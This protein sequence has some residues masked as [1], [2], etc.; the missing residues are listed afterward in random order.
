LMPGT[1]QLLAPAGEADSKQGLWHAAKSSMR[2]AVLY[3]N[4]NG[5]PSA[6]GQ[7]G[8]FYSIPLS[9]G[10]DP[11]LFSDNFQST[12]GMPFFAS[13]AD[14]SFLLYQ[15]QQGGIQALE[16]MSTHGLNLSIP[17]SR[18]GETI[19]VRSARWVRRYP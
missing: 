2:I 6:A 19:G 16:L 3:F 14:G 4:N 15:R 11:F 7:V 5:V 17:L 13:S 18:A 9:G 12:G 8:R 10:G 1:P